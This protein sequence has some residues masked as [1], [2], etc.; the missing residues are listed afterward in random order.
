MLVHLPP[1]YIFFKVAALFAF[2]EILLLPWSRWKQNHCT[3]P[4]FTG[5]A[6]AASHIWKTHR[7]PSCW[8]QLSNSAATACIPPLGRASSEGYHTCQSIL[9]TPTQ[10][11]LFICCISLQL[12]FSLLTSL[13]P[14]LGS[15]EKP[16]AEDSF[17]ICLFSDSKWLRFHYQIQVIVGV[18]F[19][20]AVVFFW[21]EVFFVCLFKSLLLLA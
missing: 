13:S 6:D 9:I 21:F 8:D 19:G 16:S 14:S 7:V 20:F 5:L 15:G 12:V 1:S 10:R 18:F 2:M 11:F 3:T 17:E 4:F